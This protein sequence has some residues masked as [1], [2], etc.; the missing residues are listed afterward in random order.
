MKKIGILGG[1]SPE[2]TTLYYEHIT[3]TYTAQHGDYGYPEILIYSVNFQKFV[4]WQRNG[5]W[6]E[7]AREMAGALERLR[8]AG[9]DFGLIATNT[10][11]FVFDE[12]QREVRMP[13]LSIVDA[14]VEAIL[15]AGLQTVG[16]LGSVFTM[17]ERFFLDVLERSGIAALVPEPGDQLKVHG[18]I[19]QELCRGEIRPESRLLLLE[20]IERLRGRGA[21]GIILGCT[22]IPLLLQPEHCELPLFNTALLHAGKALRLAVQAEE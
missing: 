2:S 11:H 9:A 17:R 14:T 7:A 15:G 21:Q 10:M 13:L 22:E 20:I 8:L 12:V 5:Q 1:M 19:F 6:D 4:D 3:R 18:V 16:L